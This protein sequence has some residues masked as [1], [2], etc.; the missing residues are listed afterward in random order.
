MKCHGLSERRALRVIGM[1]ASAYRYQPAEDHR[2]AAAPLT[3]RRQHDFSEAAPI[4]RVGQSKAVERLYAQAGLQVKRSKRKKTP[5]AK[6]HPLD[7]SSDG[8]SGV[9]YGLVF[10]R[11]AEGRCIKSLTVVDDA[12]HEAVAIVA[13]RSLSGSQ[14][15]RILEELAV[16]G[17][18][19]RP[20]EPITAKNFAADP[21]SIGRM[22]GVCNCS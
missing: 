19:P 8:Q 22:L 21:W 20:S 6:R 14:L 3:L 5:M 7:S 13:E 17:V 11:T 16:N 10:D 1:S 15:V 18:C 4:W 9:V 12:T 2:I